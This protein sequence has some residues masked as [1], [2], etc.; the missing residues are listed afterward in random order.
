MGRDLAGGQHVRGRTSRTPAVASRRPGCQR[1]A[2]EMPLV[3]GREQPHDAMQGMVVSRDGGARRTWGALTVC[4]CVLALAGC[5]SEHRAA[6]EQSSGSG[7]P[8]VAARAIGAHYTLPEGE[9]GLPRVRVTTAGPD[10]I[11]FE[12]D[13]PEDD[14]PTH[15][16]VI[17]DGDR[18]YAHLSDFDEPY[19]LYDTPEKSGGQFYDYVRSW[20]LLPGSAR[21]AQA[22]RGAQ[23]IGTRLI[24]GRTAVGYRCGP[25][26]H[27]L[28]MITAREMW[29]DRTSGLVLEAGPIVA[30]RID[31]HPPVDRSTFSTTPPE[32]V[33]VKHFAAK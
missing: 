26:A 5:R 21:L 11:R 18:L 1:P 12:W 14:P 2:V 23:R 3:R 4:A 13:I 6:A 17:Y 28:Q 32:G 30:D 15:W 22:C 24:L 31:P 10:L 29:V 33:H 27:G 16:L 19:Q 7:P 9:I 8:V 25:P 20:V